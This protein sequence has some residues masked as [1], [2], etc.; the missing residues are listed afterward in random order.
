MRIAGLLTLIVIVS[1]QAF[2]QRVSLLRSPKSR[3]L[4][5]AFRSGKLPE[6][7]RLPQGNV[8]QQAAALAKAVTTS[9]DSSTAALYAAILASGYGV[10]DADGSVMQTTDNGQGLVLQSWEVAA[11]AKL[12]GEDYGVTLRHLSD[13][14]TRTVP[15]LKDVPLANGLLDGIRAGAKSNHAAVR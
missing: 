15:E 5:Q 4:G 3:A 10:R 12:Y 6:P 1:G 2:G 8:D 13:T 14:F 7:M 11:A 9:D